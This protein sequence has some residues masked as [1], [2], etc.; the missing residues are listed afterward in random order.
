M[1]ERCIMYTLPK[2]ITQQKLK[3]KGIKSCFENV[4]LFLN[5]CT[6][7]SADDDPKISL[8]S[9][10][11]FSD[12]DDPKIS[13]NI[14]LDITNLFGEGKTQPLS[15]SYPSGNPS[16]QTKTDWDL[17]G[18]DL[19]KALNYLTQGQPWPKYTFG[20]VELIISYFFKLINPRT[21]EI[22]YNQKSDSH[23]MIWISRTNS[24]SP[25]LYFPF[26]EDNKEFRSYLDEIEPYLP[27][28]LERKHLRI[29]TENKT[30]KTI[31][32]RKLS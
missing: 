32:Y 25:T 16:T 19:N 7:I 3:G 9:Y 31:S 12:D 2:S 29:V 13:N 17:S 22:L 14:L 24:C 23:L 21:K 11:A 4:S 26:A 28:K 6:T 15:Y 1:I 5:A 8:T 27:F 20:P 10:S 30:K 18:E